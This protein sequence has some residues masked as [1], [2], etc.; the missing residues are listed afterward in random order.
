LE[1]ETCINLTIGSIVRHLYVG[2]SIGEQLQTGL[3]KLC[4]NIWEV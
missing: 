3:P 4:R 2:F 1:N